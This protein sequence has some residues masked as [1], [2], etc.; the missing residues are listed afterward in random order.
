M[1]KFDVFLKLSNERIKKT[2]FSSV[3]SAF[4]IILILELICYNTYSYF[5]LAPKSNILYTD[6]SR[7]P[8][9]DDGFVDFKRIKKM[10]VRLD[11]EFPNVPCYYIDFNVLNSFR[12]IQEDVRSEMKFLSYTIDGKPIEIINEPNDI[13]KESCG[14]CYGMKSGCCNTCNDVR[15]AY[16]DKGMPIPPLIK[17]KQC[18]DLVESYKNQKQKCRIKGSVYVPPS[19]GTILLTVGKSYF[20]PES[21]VYLLSVNPQAFNMTYKIHNFQIGRSIHQNKQLNGK[22]VVQDKFGIFNSF[23]FLKIMRANDG[24][25]VNEMWSATHQTRYKDGNTTQI[26][27]VFF[28]YDVSPI[29]S[30]EYK[31]ESILNFIVNQMAIV[32]GV[33]SLC[34]MIDNFF[35]FRGNDLK[36]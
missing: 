16:R 30:M 2:F 19:H 20:S 1:E 23:Y 32:G 25:K 27:G 29:I 10:E 6:Y 33:F 5:Y 26:A 17:I 8:V 9:D 7:L 3:I 31:R 18:S 15:N 24:K 12:D 35:N 36:L 13:S 14:S 21:L 22:Y 11:I 34:M 4:C 28:K